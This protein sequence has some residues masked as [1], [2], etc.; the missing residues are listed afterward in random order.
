MY[1]EIKNK[2]YK[3]Y[4]DRKTCPEEKCQLILKQSLNPKY[5][6]LLTVCRPINSKA[7]IDV[8]ILNALLKAESVTSKN[9]KSKLESYRA[10][11]NLALKW[12]RVDIA[13]NF[14]FTDDIK[15]CVYLYFNI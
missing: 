10:Q 2:I 3:E 4:P 8:A 9:E 1:E 15:D 7:E 14:I 6:H 13:K 12:N 5:Q 11:L